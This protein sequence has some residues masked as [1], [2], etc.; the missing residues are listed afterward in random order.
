M[1]NP[2]FLQEQ[3]SLLWTFMQLLQQCQMTETIT[4]R[5]TAATA[6]FA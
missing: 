4:R 1:Q 2:F 6:L 3:K 5:T